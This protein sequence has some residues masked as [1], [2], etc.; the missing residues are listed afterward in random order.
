MTH[1]PHC[2]CTILC[3]AS[4]W[5]LWSQ[6]KPDL[7]REGVI[8]ALNEADHTGPATKHGM[9]HQI[10]GSAVQFHEERVQ[11]TQGVHLQ[12]GN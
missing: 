2:Y 4:K 11:D 5:R 10:F 7:S 12:S 8:E 6:G 9:V 3:P 1:L